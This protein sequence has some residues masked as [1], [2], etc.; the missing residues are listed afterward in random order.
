M[1][2]WLCALGLVAG[3]CS[4]NQGGIHQDAGPEFPDADPSCVPTGNEQCNGLDDDCDGPIDEDFPTLDDPCDG[5]D[6][7]DCAEGT[8][9]CS[10]D[11]TDVS[12]TDDD[13]ENDV[14]T[15]DGTDEDCDGTPDDG[16][17]VGMPCDGD[18]DTDLCQEGS[19]E[20]NGLG[21]VQCNDPTGS[22]VELCDVGN[23]MDEDCDG[24]INEDWNF[25]NDKNNCGA[26]N[27]V[28]GTTNASSTDCVT[29]N[30]VPNC[31]AGAMDCDGDHITGCEQR[32]T[33]PVC[34]SAVVNL[35]S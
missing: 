16:F 35:G 6:L 18:G 23:T 34:S 3:G 13:T 5:A 17:D 28:C 27:T 26:C 29:S 24:S 22:T 14:E 15:C 9:V 11:G 7:D 32:N 12:C 2:R 10:Q 21:G 25:T 8:F 33:D 1:V 30:C 19:W 4:F 31:N 20:C